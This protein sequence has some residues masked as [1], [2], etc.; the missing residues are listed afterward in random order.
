MNILQRL[1]TKFNY[2][3]LPDE[4]KQLKRFL[5]FKLF[6]KADKTKFRK[7]PCNA[8]FATP[9]NK[10]G[11]IHETEREAW[12]TFDEALKQFNAGLCDG[13]GISLIDTNLIVAD[14]DNQVTWNTGGLYQLSQVLQDCLHRNPTFIE[15]SYSA[16]G[17]HAFFFG[18][19]P[20]DKTDFAW[21]ELLG[22]NPKQGFIALTGLQLAGSNSNVIINGQEWIDSIFV[23]VT[24]DEPVT[25]PT[26]TATKPVNFTVSRPVVTTA[27]SNV[28]VD[29]F[30]VPTDNH[31]LWKII[32]RSKNGDGEKQFFTTVNESD[33]YSSVLHNAL[34]SLAWWTGNDANRMLAML[35]DTPLYFTPGTK[36]KAR[37]FDDSYYAK[38]VNKAIIKTKDR[39]IPKGTTIL[40]NG[41]N[42][43]A[44]D[45]TEEE[46]NKAVSIISDD[47][48]YDPS[49]M[50][51]L[52]K[53]AQVDYSLGNDVC[54]WLGEYYKFS[55]YWSPEGYFDFHL[56][57]G[58]WILSTVAAGRIQ[59]SMSNSTMLYLMIVGDSSVSKTETAKL[60]PAV[61]KAAK[62]YDLLLEGD[63][64]P[65]ALLSK[66]AVDK[67]FSAQKGL[68]FDEIGRLF[69]KMTNDSSAWSEYDR[70]LKAIYGGVD[71]YNSH[72]VGRGETIVNNPY[73]ALLGTVVTD[74]IT[75]KAMPDFWLDGM[76]ARMNWA[77]APKTYS[78]DKTKPNAIMTV[79]DSITKPLIDW[80]NRLSPLADNEGLLPDV[81]LTGA[82]TMYVDNDVHAAWGNYRTALK[83]L[84]RESSNKDLVP[85][86]NRLSTFAA[87]IAMLT[88][89]FDGLDSIDMPHWIHAQQIAE[90]FRQ[91]LHQMY[92]EIA[93][94]QGQSKQ[95]ELENK[96]L[97]RLTKDK[98]GLTFAKLQSFLNKNNKYTV[99][100]MY[101][102]LENLIKSQLVT[103]DK[104]GKADKFTLN[105]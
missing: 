60:A 62:L 14:F 91:S 28:A 103:V 4:L 6:P 52:P 61:I 3:A 55:S 81:I 89:S 49:G 19:K 98:T 36:R 74:S 57:S 41:E 96:I 66:M 70:F 84:G 24:A 45:V 78:L 97:E 93:S 102:T 50:P 44:N 34:K 95:G 79:P 86:Y 9:D 22:C 2:D 7:V 69:S 31:E 30:G 13:I 38:E 80:H 16:V 65:Q 88:A 94:S 18:K 59:S 29:S 83:H 82:V 101:E 39:W 67:P 35:K 11:C 12:M 15:W 46:L 51:T 72:T 104:S 23:G 32:R 26:T 58:L 33:D 40:S 92:H 42:A 87:R 77:Y 63:Y 20:F 48:Q 21:G 105:L 25:E 90:I 47:T 100:F 75:P 54:P 8:H 53:S 5:G 43:N 99:K 85:N 10:S 17:A 73:L 71:N 37:L 27:N 76:F 64:T 56:A 68:F 1:D